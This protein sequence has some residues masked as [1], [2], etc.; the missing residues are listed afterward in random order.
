MDPIDL[1]ILIHAV[2]EAS[3]VLKNVESSTASLG[4]TAKVASEQT[5][6][7]GEA[8]SG[9]LQGVAVGI[10]IT[11]ATE[12]INSLG[13]AIPKAIEQ[14]TTFGQQVLTMSRQ[15]GTSAETSSA[16]LAAFERYGVSADQASKSLGLFAKNLN[17]FADSSAAAQA[18]TTGFAGAVNSLGLS[19]KDSSGN[20]I[21]MDQQLLNLADK[22]QAMPDGIQKTA[23]AVALFGRS[24]K[25]MILLLDQG[26]AGLQEAMDAAQRYGL[27]LSGDDV[28]AVRQFGLAHKDLDEAMSGVTLQIGVS[29]IPLLAKLA[30]GA[31]GLAQGFNETVLPAIKGFG[32]SITTFTSS[33]AFQMWAARLEVVI[34]LIGDGI[35]ALAGVFFSALGGILDVVNTVGQAIYQGMQWLNPFAAHSPP[36]VSQVQDGVAAINV[37]YGSL[38]G[39]SATF[40]GIGTSFEDLS[41]KTADFAS[42]VDDVATKTE[43]ALAIMGP[44]VTDAFNA[45]SDAM[46][47]A[48]DSLGDIKSAWDDATAALVPLKDNL[49]AAQQGLKDQ[50]SA[51]SDLKSELADAQSAYDPLNNA[52][53]DAEQNA[54][55]AQAAIQ[56]L[57]SAPIAGTAAFDTQISNANIAL[58]QQSLTLDTVKQSSA[59]TDLSTQIAQATTKLKDMQQLQTASQT[60]TTVPFNA[61]LAQKAAATKAAAESRAALQEQQNLLS[62]LKTKQTDL[63]APAQTK[64]QTDRDSLATI[65]LQKDATI[66][67]AQEQI[68]QAAQAASGITEQTPAQILAQIGTQGADK[69]AALSQVATLTPEVSAALANVDA[70]KAKI[71]EQ[72]KVVQAAQDAAKSANDTYTEAKTKVDDLGKAY[73]STK[74]E[75]AN[76]DAQLKATISTGD[77]QV[78]K[79]AAAAAA[80]K[81]AAAAAAKVT[82]PA[83]TADDPTGGLATNLADAKQKAEDFGKAVDQAKIDVANF[84]QPVSDAASALQDFVG[85]LGD[86]GQWLTTAAVAFAV[87]TVAAGPVGGILGM[88]GGALALL[89][90]P[91]GLIILGVAALGI[92]I[93]TNFGGIRTTLQP[94]VDMFVSLQDR[95]KDLAAIL[96]TAFQTGGFDGLV[97]AVKQMLPGI[98]DE[99]SAFT[100]QLV[101]W[102]LDVGDQLV[103]QV[104]LWAGAFLDWVEPIVP[105]VIDALSVLSN[106]ILAWVLSVADVLVDHL[107]AWGAAFVNWLL[108]QIPGILSML[109]TVALKIIDWIAS[110]GSMLA[111]HLGQWAAEFVAWIIPLLPKL[112][113]ALEQIA[114]ATID[115]IFTATPKIL[116]AIASWTGAFLGWVLPMLPGLLVAL[117]Q[118]LL[119]LT[120]WI[121]TVAVP[122]IATGLIAWGNEF[123]AWITPLLPPLLAELLKLG[124]ALTD[125]IVAEAVELG[126]N[127]IVW[128]NAFLD[129][130]APQ[131]IPFLAELGKLSLAMLGWIVDRAK[132]LGA[133]VITEWGPAFLSWIGQVLKDLPS[134]IS[135]I[136]DAIGTWITGTAVPWA[137]LNLPPFGT[138]I[139]AVLGAALIVVGAT[140]QKL[141]DAIGQWI[142]ETAL[143][144]IATNLSA[145]GKGII[146]AIG[147]GFNGLGDLLKGLWNGVEADLGAG[148]HYSGTK[149]LTWTGPALSIPL[150]SVGGGAGGSA[151]SPGVPQPEQ[152]STAPNATPGGATDLTHPGGAVA[153]GGTDYRAAAIQA[154]IAAGID[155][156]IFSAQ[157]NQESG[158]RQTNADG[159]ILK[160]PKGALG[161]AQFMP[162]TAAGVGLD[163]TN[164]LASLDAAAKMDADLLVKYGGDWS[165][166]LASYNAGAGAVDK[167]NGVPPYAETQAYVSSILAAAAN[168][169]TGVTHAAMIPGNQGGMNMTAATVGNTTGL[170]ATDS[171]LNTGVLDAQ[172]F[173]DQIGISINDA[174]KI[175]MDGGK[176][177]QTV[178]GTQLPAATNLSDVAVQK[179]ADTLGISWDDART[180]LQAGGN[181]ADAV[182][183]KQIP[184]AAQTTVTAVSGVGTA[185]SAGLG[186]AIFDAQRF[187]NQMGISIDDANKIILNHGQVAQAIFGTQLPA[188]TQISDLA[189]EKFADGM[190]IGWDTARAVLTA[191]GSV[192]DAVM[193][194]DI[195]AAA[196]TSVTAIADI[197]KNVLWQP[198]ISNAA[199]AGKDLKAYIA[200]TGAQAIDVASASLADLE[201]ASGLSLPQIQLQAQHAGQDID[202][203]LRKTGVPAAQ[204]LAG[205]LGIKDTDGTPGV[206]GA[207]ASI[208]TPVSAA[209]SVIAPM[210]AAMDVASQTQLA[211]VLLL[212]KSGL[213]GHNKDY[214]GNGLIQDVKD[215]TAALDAIHNVDVTIATHYTST[216]TPSAAGSASGSSSSSGTVGDG[217]SGPG[218]SRNDPS[219]GHPVVNNPVSNTGGGGQ[220]INSSAPGA[221]RTNPNQFAL[222]G[223]VGGPLGTA[224]LAVVHG[225]E[226]ILTPDQWSTLNKQVASTMVAGGGSSGTA[227]AQ[228]MHVPRP[229]STGA[230]TPASSAPVIDYDKLGAAVAKA[231][232][233]SPPR[234]AVEDVR[235]SLLRVGSR[236]G[237]VVGL[238]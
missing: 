190:G 62:D 146:D 152:L 101:K 47:A 98:L 38:G 191:G 184:A 218:G 113:I 42:T 8:F 88:I 175:L 195:P 20:L 1:Q 64:L 142:T 140:F 99:L 226:M 208:A 131:V 55:N 44:G 80:A 82:T 169:Q 72:T 160:S 203:W 78:Q 57:T 129:W 10:G 120:V 26:S 201:K 193:G 186:G 232:H 216:G 127:L 29:L 56:A 60:S 163:P 86:I 46:Q 236:N 174:N 166:V 108:P 58:K 144:W 171:A 123:I 210:G 185:V 24:G 121:V 147:A 3:A 172:K 109:A 230:S 91:I 114:G 25:Q 9:L 196:Q 53:K 104:M 213:E 206:A 179:Y 90:S 143:P 61:T 235:T 227:S 115:F 157:I 30:E 22:F 133:K 118:L 106:Q 233:A 12:A 219:T 176:V 93:A 107:L 119:G 6:K 66:G 103:A 67:V 182:M 165:K 94:A 138:A 139:L 234:V 214:P 112:G 27:V 14:V 229:S 83:T 161:I 117:G 177:A 77:M 183:G 97:T 76:Y 151:A 164:A 170:S 51:L 167:Y 2:D 150:P 198:L 238:G 225:G 202:T 154:A 54:K 231:L 149:G 81:S 100:V 45:A 153:T 13:E 224:M 221:G 34:G 134:N 36:L 130:I 223:L 199:L 181:I 18:K 75:I 11:A 102:A 222:G 116:G 50:Q 21:P 204:G 89:L 41:T 220:L 135:K 215:F 136:L 156:A 5:S 194:K 158:F 49:D 145:L 110:A 159:S 137:T 28:D 87:F 148:I 124:N 197:G 19:V 168:Y 192:A 162:G 15:T 79:A 126:T 105:K 209:T 132:D 95:L 141:L 96:M 122:K 39:L 85:P 43:K 128:G 187:A 205:A 68:K 23:D 70:M 4:E 74:T 40:D 178:F 17:T 59:Y 65:Q 173:A 237:G 63:L 37:A 31:A 217:S 211:A 228:Y 52:L 200:G 7:L 111:E 92:A 84:F 33:D 73:S 155:P 35:G 180:A 125:W 71:A 32:D 48:K 188:A 16:L 212:L 207:A 189:V 69:S